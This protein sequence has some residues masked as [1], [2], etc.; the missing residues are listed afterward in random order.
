MQDLYINPI[1]TSIAWDDPKRNLDN[2][3]K[4]IEAKLLNFADIPSQSQIFIF[5][6][7]ILSGFI[8]KEPGKH[9]LTME[10]SE[11]DELCNIAK[12]H[13]TAIVAA[14]IERNDKDH[15]KPFNTTVAINSEGKILEKYHKINLFT[16]GSP[17]ERDSY[18]AGNKLAIFELNGYRIGITVCFDLRFP[19]LFIA[20]AEQGVD[21]ILAPSCWVGGPYK[22][23]QFQRLA[24][25]QA[26]TTQ[27]YVVAVNRS[28][29]DPNFYYH[30]EECI[31]APN[32]VSVYDY[33][34]Y[35]I[36]RELIDAARKMDVFS[37]R[38]TN[39]LR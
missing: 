37:N 5:P 28:G 35:K 22:S 11:V 30:G 16:I 24:C 17:S 4:T 19:E 3:N 15:E 27:S 9:S 38:E 7:L 32:G 12:R 23:L 26:I 20:Y 6:E 18:S 10:S 36:D 29:Q 25:A 13:Q 31:F 1:S 33:A 2:I 14:F 34:P 21:I 39:Y 8:T